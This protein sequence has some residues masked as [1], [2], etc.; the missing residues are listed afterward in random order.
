MYS[1]RISLYLGQIRIKCISV[2]VS[3]LQNGRAK[4]ACVVLVANRSLCIFN[5]ETPSYSYK[6]ISGLNVFQIVQVG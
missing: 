5:G 1:S 4:S 3:F 2:L 6:E